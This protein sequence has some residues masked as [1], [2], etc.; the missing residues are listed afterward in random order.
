MPKKMK[1]LPTKYWVQQTSGMTAEV[2]KD[3]RSFD[4]ELKP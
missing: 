4:F 2:A 1:K 3:K